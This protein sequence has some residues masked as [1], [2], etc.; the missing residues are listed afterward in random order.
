MSVKEILAE[1]FTQIKG[2]KIVDIFYQPTRMILGDDIFVFN[3]SNGYSLHV[4]C[5]VKISQFNEM[6]LTTTD[7]YTTPKYEK[8]KQYDE[9]D[10]IRHALLRKTITRS[11][12]ILQNAMIVNIGISEVADL[13]IEFDNG[14]NIKIILKYMICTKSIKVIEYLK[15]VNSAGMNWKWLWSAMSLFLTKT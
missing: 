3:F 6:V 4:A 1:V 10:F 15:R 2:Q 5:F 13:N 8:M 12:R 11:K 7:Q 9:D 14:T